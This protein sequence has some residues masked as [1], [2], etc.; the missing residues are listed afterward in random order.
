M[1]GGYIWIFFAANAKPT[2]M[3]RAAAERLAE[4]ETVVTIDQPVSVLGEKRIPSLERRSKKIEDFT[5]CWLYRPLHYPQRFRGFGKIMK[6]INRGQ[7]RREL[8]ELVPR[9]TRRII[10]YDSPTQN[11]LVGKLGEDVNVYLL[12]RR[13]TPN[14]SCAS[15][16]VVGV[17]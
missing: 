6:R 1:T 15:M 3:R 2:S 11:H 17:M 14:F 7:L 12:A 13:D 4:E 5:A 16:Y 10:C 9:D 8:D